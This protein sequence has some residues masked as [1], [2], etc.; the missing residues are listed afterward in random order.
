MKDTEVMR[1][2]LIEHACILADLN[3]L[4][5]TMKKDTPSY[6]IL[7]KIINEITQKIEVEAHNLSYPVESGLLLG[8]CACD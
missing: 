8:Y 3:E 5:E 6:A 7:Q 2:L 1:A 4:Q